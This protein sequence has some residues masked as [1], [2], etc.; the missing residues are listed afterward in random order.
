MR[1]GETD[2]ASGQI[3]ELLA[4]PALLSVHEL[5]VSPDLDPIRRDPRF[6]ALLRKY[7][8]PER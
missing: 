3:E 1:V 4:R 8:N 7:A 5:R 6:Y 2:A